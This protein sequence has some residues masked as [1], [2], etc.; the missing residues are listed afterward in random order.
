MKKLL[1]AL[2]LLVIVLAVSYFKAARHSSQ[3]TSAYESGRT[4]STQDLTRQTERGDSLE[5]VAEEYRTLMV[6]SLQVRDSVQASE[7][8]SITEVL[9]TKD[10]SLARL[11][12]LAE[13]AQDSQKETS[14]KTYSHEEILKYYKSSYRGL[15]KDLSP[16]ERRVA[17]TEIRDKTTKKF[18]ITFAQLDKIRKDNNLDY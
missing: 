9:S 7:R 18:S 14:R 16:Y 17:L 3:V 1:L 8:D 15:P 6:E 5:R 2:L 11:R 4:E 12:K 10:D 13:Q